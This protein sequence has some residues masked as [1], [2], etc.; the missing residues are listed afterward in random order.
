M[1]W[2]RCEIGKTAVSRL[3]LCVKKRKGNGQVGDMI[4]VSS[5]N[6]YKN[7]FGGGFL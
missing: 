5:Y 7:I 1:F 6:H 3:F 2:N 4:G